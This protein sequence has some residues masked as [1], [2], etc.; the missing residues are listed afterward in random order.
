MEL[1]RK[2]GYSLTIVAPRRKRKGKASRIGSL[3]IYSTRLLWSLI[4]LKFDLVHA[5]WPFHA[6]LFAAAISFLRRK[7]LI[8]TS[9]GAY[10]D[11]YESRSRIVN[12]LSRFSLKRADIVIVVGRRHK[13]A[14]KRI[15]DVPSDRLRLIDEGVWTGGTR[16]TKSEARLELNLSESEKIVIFIGNI[17]KEKGVDILLRA[18]SL[19]FNEIP[20][21]YLYI[22]GQG[23]EFES[24]MAM[25]DELNLSSVT[26]VL[27]PVIPD[28]VS[29]WLAAADVCVVPSRR[30]SFGSVAVEAMVNGT[31]VIAS[32]VGGLSYTIKDGSNGCLFP[33]GDHLRLAKV[34]MRVLT[35]EA[36]RYS[37]AENGRESSAIY[38]MQ[39]RM[40]EVSNV[41][42]ELIKLNSNDL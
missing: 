41:Y 42:K 34:L 7:P 23:S 21:S 8:I 1:L 31:A 27:G 16:L 13:E 6:G 29:T 33:V 12:V 5:H 10:I 26:R 37:L 39:S 36:L 25:I 22:G 30:E 15:G 14:V 24:I 2:L 19:V 40:V 32:N 18:F 9:H 17:Q 11:D 3:L 35:D 20:D 28:N 38:D 4:T